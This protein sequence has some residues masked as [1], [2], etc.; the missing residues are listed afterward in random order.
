MTSPRACRRPRSPRS[1][2]HRG[3]VFLDL[4]LEVVFS[5]AQVEVG[6]A[7]AVPSLDP[8]PEEVARAA[9]LLAGAQRPVII[10]GSDVYAGD[11]TAAL[12]EAAEALRIPVFANGMGRGTLPP[13]H[14]LAVR[15]GPRAALSGPT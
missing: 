9:A 2:P 12:R 1:P 5:Q 7:P 4:P 8:D 13:E 3:P 6:P 14:P 15:A 10:A 11:A